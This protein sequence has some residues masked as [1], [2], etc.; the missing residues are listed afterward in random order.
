MKH[1]ISAV[2]A[3]AGFGAPQFSARRRRAPGDRFFSAGPL[4]A[5]NNIG[6]LD[7]DH[8]RRTLK[9]V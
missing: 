8:R 3:I 9:C 2:F 1:H 5:N 6:P 4:Q 7:I